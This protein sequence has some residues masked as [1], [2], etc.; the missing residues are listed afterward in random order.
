LIILSDGVDTGSKVTLPSCIEAA[1]RADTLVY[2]ILFEDPEAYQS[3]PMGGYGRR[4]RMGG[5]MPMPGAGHP[6]G[7]KV[8]EQI[9]RETGG[10]FFKVTNKEPLSTIYAEINDDLRHQ[11]SIGYTPDTPPDNRAF[12]HIHLT[13]KQKGLT[14][15]TREGYYPT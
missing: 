6:D 7:K 15:T 4:G 2:S 14:V 11:Y 13:T 1:Q 3:R 5:P 9:S 10:R 8:L 12:R